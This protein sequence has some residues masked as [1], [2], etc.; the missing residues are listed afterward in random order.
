MFQSGDK[1]D[2]IPES[3]SRIQFKYQSPSILR[4]S[5]P[6]FQNSLNGDNEHPEY[7][8]NDVPLGNVPPFLQMN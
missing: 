2:D 1:Y 7:D 3:S 8:S 6:V 4:K 5:K